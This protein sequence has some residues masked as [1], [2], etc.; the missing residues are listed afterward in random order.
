MQIQSIIVGLLAAVAMAAPAVDIEARQ[1]GRV[2]VQA[3]AC[4]NEQG[5]TTIGACLNGWGSSVD[6][7]GQE[8]CYPY[9]LANIPK[10]PELFSAS[11]CAR[12]YSPLFPISS[13]KPA[14]IC[15]SFFDQ[16]TI[17]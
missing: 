11:E 5:K 8:Y 7:D 13:C 16:Y 17:C 1:A 10:I 9:R 2:E 3:C 15:P 12:S 6:R 14:Y 4:M